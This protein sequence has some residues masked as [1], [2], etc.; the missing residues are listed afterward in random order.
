M[1]SGWINEFLVIIVLHSSSKY[2]FRLLNLNFFYVVESRLFSVA[3]AVR[4]SSE[5]QRLSG[6]FPLFGRFLLVELRTH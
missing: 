4:F 5:A 2:L 1:A 3:F 6:S